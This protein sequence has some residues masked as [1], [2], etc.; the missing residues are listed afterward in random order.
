MNASS[1]LASTTQ[2]SSG[3]AQVELPWWP[4]APGACRTREPQAEPSPGQAGSP[5]RVAAKPRRSVRCSLGCSHRTTGGDPV[6]FQPVQRSGGSKACSRSSWF[7]WE[8][9][10]KN[11]LP[12]CTPRTT[13]FPRVPH[14]SRALK[15]TS[16]PQ[17]LILLPGRSTAAP[18][19]PRPIQG[20]QDARC[21]AGP[22]G[23]T[24]KM[25]VQAERWT[26]QV[27]FLSFGS[28]IPQGANPY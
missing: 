27:L 4:K 23:Y 6:P 24:A 17:C 25:Q 18:H 19:A 14:C 28:D 7:R 12:P 1:H 2:A 15:G 13:R 8:E 9:L 20:A 3:S 26:Y 21:R 10:L 11:L 22:L 5:G 16:L